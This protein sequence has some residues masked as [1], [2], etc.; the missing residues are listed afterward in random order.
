MALQRGPIVFCLEGPDNDGKVS[1]LVIPDDA[2]I[3][4]EYKPAL[5]NGVMVL[6]G[7]AQVAKRT[8]DGGV[9]AAGTRSFTAIPYYAW[10][11]RGLTP[12]TVWPARS[13]PRPARSRRI[14]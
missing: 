12:M 8:T 3:K 5:L 9:M 6:T 13:C 4:A 10:A 11:H 2:R 7:K 1:N 14:P